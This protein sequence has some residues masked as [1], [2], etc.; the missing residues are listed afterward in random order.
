MGELDDN[1]GKVLEE[2]PESSLNAIVAIA[3]SVFATLMALGNIKDGNVVQAM[4]AAQAKTVD[5]WSYY[6]AKGM[7]RH[8]AESMADQLQIQLDVQANLAPAARERLETRMQTYQKDAKRY[9]SEQLEIKKQ[10]EGLA[11]EYDRLNVHDDQFD[12]AEAAFSV[13]I[14]LAGV[15]ALTKKRWMLILVFFFGSVG[16]VMELAGFLGWALH[17]DSLARFLG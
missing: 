3:V 4:T 1:V 14:A 17:P 12:M 6:Q 2:A 7:K 5:S 13:G 9:E 15:A 10:A 8:L 11:A 16:I